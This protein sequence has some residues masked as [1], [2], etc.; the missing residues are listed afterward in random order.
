[1]PVE[2]DPK[3]SKFI[4]ANYYSFSSLN[5]TGVQTV[6]NK[7]LIHFNYFTLMYFSDCCA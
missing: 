2:T 5:K 7:I 4:L 3:K 6:L 1:M